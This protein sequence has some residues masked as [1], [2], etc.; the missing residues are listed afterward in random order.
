MNDPNVST[1][2]RRISTG[3]TTFWKSVFVPTWITGVGAFT[4]ALWMDLIG[5][6]PAPMAVKAVVLS[7]WM[8]FSPFFVWWSRRMSHVWLDGDVLVLRPGGRDYRVP[9]SQ[10]R[11]IEES[12]FQRVKLI[13]LHLGRPSPMGDKIVLAAPFTFQKPF[14]DHPLV[15]ELKEHQRRI[16]AGD[17]P[18]RLAVDDARAGIGR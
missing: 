2:L 13:T 6:P 5:S 9:L 11:D 18:P 4:V 3:A 16:T 1:Q 10:I 7:L 17:G 8:A 15:A 12:R 14:S